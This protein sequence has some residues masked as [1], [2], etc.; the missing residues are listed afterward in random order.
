MPKCSF[1]DCEIPLP[2]SGNTLETECPRCGRPVELRPE[3]LLQTS[4]AP[5]TIILAGMISGKI[6]ELPINQ[7]LVLGRENYGSDIFQDRKFSRKHC[8]IETNPQALSICDLGSMN[9]T[10]VNGV[11]IAATTT[12]K[13]EDTIMIAD[14]TFILKINT[15]AAPEAQ[16]EAPGFVHVC[17][18]CGYQDSEGLPRC[19]ECGFGFS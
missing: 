18:N 10:F 13:N 11:R 3:N 4:S 6:L 19:P 12:L 2:T 17:A 1:C 8:L 15:P 9:G 5:A 16:P 7:S 14:E